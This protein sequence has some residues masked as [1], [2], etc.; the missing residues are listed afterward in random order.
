[1]ASVLQQRPQ[2]DWYNRNIAPFLP[3]D[4]RPLAEGFASSMQGLYGGVKDILYGG[5]YQPGQQGLREAENVGKI[6]MGL[7]DLGGATYA[8]GARGVMAKGLPKD[9]LFAGGSRHPATLDMSQE[10]RMAR[11]REMGFDTDTVWYHVT[12]S[13]FDAFDNAYLGRN[14]HGNASSDA[15]AE[16][17]NL[18]HWFTSEP[19]A[20][21]RMAGMDGTGGRTIPVYV[22]G[23][24][25]DELESGEPISLDYVMNVLD[26]RLD[27]NGEGAADRWKRSLRKRGY[28]GISLDDTE[29]G[30]RSAVVFD[31]SDIRSVSAAFD[32]AKRNSSNLLAAN[33]GQ[34]PFVPQ[35]QG[36]DGRQE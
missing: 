31:P 9:T 20:V 7:L 8:V 21:A 14:T 27:K 35:A 17:A 19:E 5:G 24:L 18:G 1:M 36:D 16:T 10:A 11:A 32:P 12:D 3:L 26:R 29:F 28:H 34:I 13:D 23:G 30:G 6:A 22:R 15:A 4:P 2:E 33:R 25:Y